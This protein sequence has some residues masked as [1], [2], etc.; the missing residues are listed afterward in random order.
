M[1]QRRTATVQN[2][3]NRA[4]EGASAERHHLTVISCK[5]CV[6]LLSFASLNVGFNQHGLDCIIAAAASVLAHGSS[7]QQHSNEQLLEHM[8]PLMSSTLHPVSCG[9]TAVL[10]GRL[11]LDVPHQSTLH[12]YAG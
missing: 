7:S 2:L 10:D 9:D 5:M 4:N 11:Q 1:D 3:S 8:L 6:S 12:W